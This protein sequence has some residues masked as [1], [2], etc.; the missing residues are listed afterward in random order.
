M[1]IIQVMENSIVGMLVGGITA[2]IKYEDLQY[3]VVENA[4]SM[5]SIA[6][7]FYTDYARAIT[8][9][10]ANVAEPDLSIYKLFMSVMHGILHGLRRRDLKVSRYYDNLE[11]RDEVRQILT[12]T[13]AHDSARTLDYAFARAFHT[14]ITSG[15]FTKG[16]KMLD[17]P[18][19]R[20][21]YGLMA[22]AY[23][24]LDHFEDDVVLSVASDEFNALVKSYVP[25]VE[26]NE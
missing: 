24:G 17:D 6:V 20:G 2:G 5:A 1:H 25:D 12:D 14:F 9:L 8:E 21:M 19:S 16:L 13:E 23:Y 10:D 11:L 3:G 7:I 4:N 22:G 15:T 26:K 18:V